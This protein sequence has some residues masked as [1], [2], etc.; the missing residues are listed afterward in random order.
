MELLKNR[1]VLGVICIS[2]SLII[3]FGVTPLFNKSASSKTEVLQMKKAVSTGELVTADMVEI[4][5]VGNYNLPSSLI[6]TKEEIVGNYALADLYVGD[7]VQSAKISSTMQEENVYLYQLNGTKQA[8]SFSIQSFANG[9]SGK[10]ESG[11]IISVIAPD[12]QDL[13]ETVIPAELKYVEVISVTASSGSD[14]NNGSYESDD[15]RVL[16]STVTVLV[17]AEQS[18]I[19][20]ELESDN[21]PHVTLVYRGDK[22][23]A[24]EFIKTQDEVIFQ[25]Y[26]EGVE[27]TDGTESVESN[28]VE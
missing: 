19:L 12:Y 20:A 25:L 21:K 24:D 7:Y 17:T 27:E 18:K 15:E 14:T 4:V 5:E 8:M 28:E 1:T 9:L 13:G 26:H 22:L 23:K 10:L 2:L 6:T 16:P 3:C 11:D